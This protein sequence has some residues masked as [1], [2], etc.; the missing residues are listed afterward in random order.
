MSASNWARCPRCAKKRAAQIEA[1]RAVLAEAYGTVPAERYEAMRTELAIAETACVA[2]PQDFREDYEITGAADGLIVVD[3]I[4]G[5][6][7]CGLRTNFKKEHKLD[8]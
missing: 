8:V 7:K 1:Q 3:Y 2:P 6:D 4:G 5:C